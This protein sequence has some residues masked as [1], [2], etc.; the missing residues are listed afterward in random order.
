ME[1]GAGRGAQGD[2]GRRWTLWEVPSR[3][4]GYHGCWVVLEGCRLHLVRW[5]GGEKNDQPCQ[6][7]V[8]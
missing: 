7:G 2:G 5:P 8:R 1:Q 4:G 3:D 6:C